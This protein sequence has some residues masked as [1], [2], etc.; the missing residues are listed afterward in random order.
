MFI[1]KRLFRENCTFHEGH[2]VKD[3]SFLNR[4]ISSI[5]IVDNSPMSYKFHPENAIDCGSF[6]NDPNDV[7]LWQIGDF[8]C[9]IRDI[10]DVR[11]ICTYWREWV[12]DNKSTAPQKNKL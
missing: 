10:D 5:I 9:G 3:L 1:G 6:I 2:Y 12:R 4:D 7:E 8:L 11:S